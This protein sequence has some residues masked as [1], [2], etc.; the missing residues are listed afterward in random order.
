MT[1]EGPQY[2]HYCASLKGMQCAKVSLFDTEMLKIAVVTYV[3]IFFSF[4]VLLKNAKKE[5]EKPFRDCADVY[6]SGFN[7]SGVYT[8]YI[9]N[10]SDPKKVRKILVLFSYL[11]ISCCPG[12]KKNIWYLYRSSHS[13]N[14]CTDINNLC[15]IPA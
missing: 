12:L 1:V 15:C 11:L 10:V 5:E 14:Y 8:I 7:K 13:S 2:S 3:L 9:N 6:Q 4:A